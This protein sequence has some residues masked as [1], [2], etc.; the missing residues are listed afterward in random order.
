V[1]DMFDPFTEA[2]I[3]AVSFELGAVSVAL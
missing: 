2:P 3:V 1:L